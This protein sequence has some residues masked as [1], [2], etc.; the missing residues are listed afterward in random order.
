MLASGAQSSLKVGLT[1]RAPLLDEEAEEGGAEREGVPPVVV[2]WSQACGGISWIRGWME[3]GLGGRL[4]RRKAKKLF[5]FLY[6]LEKSKSK[7]MLLKAQATHF[8]RMICMFDKKNRPLDRC[9]QP[10]CDPSR[11]RGNT[12]G[13]GMKRKCGGIRAGSAGEGLPRKTRVLEAWGNG[14][15]PPP[16]PCVRL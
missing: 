6:F 7:S 10:P 2:R 13:W 3:M 1:P 12:G 8:R 9:F 14:C 15:T 11:K 16:V 5:L 4:R